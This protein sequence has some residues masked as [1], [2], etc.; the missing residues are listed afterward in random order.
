VK[1]ID[2]VD[3]WVGGLAETHI[4]GGQ[5]GQTFWVVLQEQFDRLQE[6]DRFYYLNRMENFDIYKNNIEEQGLSAIISRNTGLTNL[7]DDIFHIATA[8]NGGGDGAGDGN[9]N[10]NGDNGGGTVDHGGGTGDHG[11]GTG[12]TGSTG[13]TGAGTGTPPA[14]ATP[15]TLV[16][17]ATDNLLVGQ[18]G[19]DVA[20]G[21]GGS[22]MLSTAGG[23][24]ALFGGAGDDTMFGGAGDDMVYGEEGN[25]RIFAGDGIDMIKGGAG[26]DI[27]MGGAGDDIFITS[28]NDG[29]DTYYGDAGIDTLDMSSIIDRIEA[30]LG[31]GF[32]N[33]GYAQTATS[34]DVLWN[35]ENIVT[36]AGNDTIIASGATNVI[37]TGAGHDTVVFR[38]ASDANHDTILNFEAGDKIDVTGFMGSVNLVNGSTAAAGQ[39]AISFENINGENF[40]VLHGQDANHNSF[41]VDIKGHHQLTAIDFVS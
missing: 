25:D 18:G 38:S 36:G 8:Q 4:N 22:D 1:G 7:P 12:G 39:I 26:D 9:G 35:V 23:N 27:A 15:L 14:P 31:T 40:T 29:N 32:N 2:R 33:G 19:D 28:P 11:G 21:N 6:G 17:D 34:H 41:E 3:L 16:G 5:V 10:G 20:L 30:N 24:D 13:G 37:D